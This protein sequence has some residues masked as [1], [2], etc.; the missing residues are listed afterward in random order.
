MQNDRAEG[1]KESRIILIQAKIGRRTPKGSSL[2]GVLGWDGPAVWI[3]GILRMDRRSPFVRHVVSRHGP[4]SICSSMR[5]ILRRC[6]QA[7]SSSEVIVM[8]ARK[9]FRVLARS[10]SG[11][12]PI[13]RT[14]LMANSEIILVPGLRES[15]GGS[16]SQHD[17]RRC[18][19]APNPHFDG[20]QQNGLFQTDPSFGFGS[21]FEPR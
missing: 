10:A 17:R 2:W 11:T 12:L 18:T 6:A 14:L 13:I 8:A 9:S 3:G 4:W 1:K 7:R 19:E 16:N 5:S 15:V 20:L 21:S